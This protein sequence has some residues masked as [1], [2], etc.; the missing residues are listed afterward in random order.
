MIKRKKNTRQR[1]SHTHGWGS[2][3]KHRGAGNR[4]GRGNAGSGKR[5]DAKKPSF[6]KD[7]SYY[8][9]KGFKS[10][11]K[12]LKT[13]NISDLNKFEDTKIDLNKEGFNK[14]L[15]QGTPNQKYEIIVSYASKTAI[16]KITKAGGKVS[17]L[18]KPKPK[19]EKKEVSETQG[20][21]APGAPKENLSSEPAKVVEEEV[22]LEVSEEETV[23][24][25]KEDSETK[26]E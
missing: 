7:K 21:K 15:S 17:G 26:E 11:R 22:E 24:E 18:V 19:K 1:G 10:L 20:S 3:K 6:W 16:E 14:L 2:K 23:K 8:K 25:E 9:S 5:G 4:G 12:A 13:L